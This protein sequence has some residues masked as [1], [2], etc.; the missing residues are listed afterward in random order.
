MLPELCYQ[1]LY[2]IAANLLIFRDIQEISAGKF[3]FS[4]YTGMLIGY[5]ADNNIT[6]TSNPTSNASI[7]DEL[8]DIDKRLVLIIEQ[9]ERS[10]KEM[11]NAFMR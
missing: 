2:V 1:H 11:M 7:L 10:V 8:S 5:S 4:R 6:P 3:H 9:E